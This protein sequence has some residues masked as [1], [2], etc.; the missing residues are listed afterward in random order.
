MANIR[1]PSV[2][3][4]NVKYG[5][6]FQTGHFVLIRSE[7]EIGDDCLVGTGTIIDGKVKIGN[8]VKIQSAVYIPP[9]TIIHDNVFV[10]PRVCFTN[11][12]YMYY[13]AELK[14]AEI[15]E[16]TRIGANATILPGVKIGK[17]CLI[18]GGS[19]VTQNLPDNS[20]A[21]GNPAKIAGKTSKLLAK[22]QKGKK[23]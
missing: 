16:G 23:K 10:G 15:G 17:N 21:Y 8:N 5:K 9:N 14:G 3:Y 20:V 12:K 11:D 2:I 7:T 19:V 18:G 13:G 22:K 4:E 1:Q 6:N